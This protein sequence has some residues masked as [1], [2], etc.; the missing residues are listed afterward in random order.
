MIILFTKEHVGMGQRLASPCSLGP[1]QAGCLN[2]RKGKLD[3][4]L[5]MSKRRKGRD[6]GLWEQAMQNARSSFSLWHWRPQSVL[7]ASL[8]EGGAWL[9][10]GPAVGTG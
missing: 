10:T 6:Q 3:Q 7:T 4:R 1:R 8:G 9:R 5:S 2:L